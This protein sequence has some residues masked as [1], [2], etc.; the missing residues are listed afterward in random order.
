MT[1]VAL[2]D[3]ELS[4]ELPRQG[5]DV[6]WA[7]MAAPVGSMAV[8]IGVRAPVV[9]STASLWAS[10]SSTATSAVVVLRPEPKGTERPRRGRG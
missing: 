4:P 8:V 9:R 5:R 7:L 6:A 3:S 1:G 2:D 10:L